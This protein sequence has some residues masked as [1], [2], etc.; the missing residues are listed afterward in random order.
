MNEYLMKRLSENIKTKK[1]NKRREYV[2]K[3]WKL[4]I[5]KQSQCDEK[6]IKY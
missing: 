2:T 5:N 1:K 6:I 4:Y 3:K